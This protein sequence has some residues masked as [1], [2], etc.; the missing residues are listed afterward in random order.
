VTAFCGTRCTFIE[1]TRFSFFKRFWLFSHQ[2]NTALTVTTGVPI[3]ANRPQSGILRTTRN[4]ISAVKKTNS[5][6]QYIVR[7]SRMSFVALS[8][9]LIFIL[10]YYNCKY[11]RLYAYDVSDNV[12]CTS[13]RVN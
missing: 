12:V 8:A 10:K 4:Y 1:F 7:Q 2:K 5:F 9:L 3:F 13:L 11:Y 6:G